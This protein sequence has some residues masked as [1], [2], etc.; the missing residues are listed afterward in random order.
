MF[1]G[2]RQDKCSA[3]SYFLC[4]QEA[5]SGG[6]R[7]RKGRKD[8]GLREVTRST[9]ALWKIT[10]GPRALWRSTMPCVLVA[11]VW[12]LDHHTAHV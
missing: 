6:E 12:P 11:K 3:G 1:R 7:E 2:R 8:G 4:P 10:A 9:I 5:G